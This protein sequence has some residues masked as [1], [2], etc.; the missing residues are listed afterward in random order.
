MKL[1]I[2]LTYSQILQLDHFLWQ[3][4][5]F[6]HFLLCSLIISEDVFLYLCMLDTFHIFTKY[7]K[8]IP[9]KHLKVDIQ[10]L[11]INHWVIQIF[12]TL[13][14]FLKLTQMWKCEYI[15]HETAHC[16]IGL[17]THNLQTI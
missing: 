16:Y 4:I 1:E 2:L 8:R 15:K 12:K 6:N 13:L 5:Y 17:K 11:F 9:K 10:Q 3:I 7:F 14:F